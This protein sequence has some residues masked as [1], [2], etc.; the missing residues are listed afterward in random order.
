MIGNLTLPYRPGAYV[1]EIELAT[2]TEQGL[3]NFLPYTLDDYAIRHGVAL[4]DVRPVYLVLPRFDLKDEPAC[5]FFDLFGWPAGQPVPQVKI[6]AYTPAGVPFLIPLGDEIT[7]QTRLTRLREWPLPPPLDPLRGNEAGRDTGRQR[8]QVLALVGNLGRLLWV[9]AGEKA[10]LTALVRQVGRQRFLSSAQGYSLDLIGQEL[11]VPRGYPAAYPLDPATIA[12]YHLDDLEDDPFGATTVGDRVIDTTGRHHGTNEDAERGVEGRFYR[13]FRFR[14]G[15]FPHPNC[16]AEALFQERLRNGDWNAEVGD[17]EVRY[18]P[19]RVFGYRE[20]AIEVPG[21]DGHP[22]GVW[23]NDEAEDPH[24]RGMITSACYGFIPHDLNPTIHHFRERG[25]PVRAAI[26]Y[27]GRWWGRDHGWFI[28]NYRRHGLPEPGEECI[29]PE[30]PLTY[31]RIPNHREFA[32]GRERSFTVEA[33]ILAEP[34]TDVRL[35]VIAIKSHELFYGAPM[36][37]HCAEGWALTLGTFDCIANNVAWSISDLPDDKRYAAPH[38]EPR[39]VT[40]T[41]GLDLAD[42]RWHHVAGVIDRRYQVARLY[43]DGVQR[44]CA[45]ISLVG[46]IINDE[47][48]LLGVNDYHFDAPFDGRIDEVRLSNVARRAFHP[49]LGEGDERYRTRLRLYRPWVIPTEDTLRRGVQEILSES[50]F[51]PEVPALVLPNIDLQEED[52]RRVCAELKLHFRPLS[53]PP[54]GH[55]DG[56]GDRMTSLEEICGAPDE[57]FLEAQLI[58]HDHPDLAYATPNARRM[59]LGAAQAV[60]ALASR[61]KPWF[62]GSGGRLEVLSAYTPGGDPLQT[63]GR[64]IELRLPGLPTGVLAAFA[65]AAGCDWVE[66]TVVGGS[67]VIAAFAARR[68]VLEIA[69]DN[70]ALG[71]DWPERGAE[72]ILELG[73]SIELVVVRP[74]TPPGAT[75]TWRVVS[76]GPGRARLEVNPATPERARLFPLQ[77]GLV[78][79]Q[80]EMTVGR[81]TL[82]GQRAARLRPAVLPPCET[83][84]ADGTLGLNEAEAAGLPTD[85]FHEAFLLPFPGVAGALEWAAAVADQRVQLG[86]ERVLLRL[87]ALLAAE[88]GGAVAAQLVAGYDPQAADLRRLA[89][90]V[91]LT[92]TDPAQL[93]LGRLA[94]LAHAAGFAWVSYPAFGDNIEAATGSEPLLEIVAGPIERLP[95]NGVLSWA[96]ILRADVPEGPLLA[97]E[98]FNAADPANHHNRPEVDY[99]GGTRSHLMQPDLQANLDDLI[100]LLTVENVPGRLQVLGAFDDTAP[101]RRRVGRG[102]T[103]R[104]SDLPLDRLGALAHA[105][106]FDYVRYVTTPALDP[107]THYLYASTWASL[108]FSSLGTLDVAEIQDFGLL[109]LDGLTGLPVGGVR[110]LCLRPNPLAWVPPRVEEPPAGEAPPNLPPYL[111][112]FPPGAHVEFCLVRCDPAWGRLESPPNPNCCWLFARHAV[113]VWARGEFVLNDATDPYRFNL[114]VQ[115][116]AQGDIPALPKALYDDLMNYLSF[117]HPVGVEARTLAV[118]AITPGVIEDPLL[119]GLDTEHTFPLYRQ[120]SLGSPR[121]PLRPGWDWVGCDCPQATPATIAGVRP[122]LPPPPQPRLPPA[123]RGEPGPEGH[124]HENEDA[125]GRR[126]RRRRRP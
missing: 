49:A 21:P 83:I 19:Y 89:R 96:G 105:A 98:S 78:F 118:R 9:L 90:Q 84:S 37:V 69:T 40:V 125:A 88:P 14:S 41:A 23:V 24:V 95:P 115:P 57:N 87:A 103:L 126:G 36:Q 112:P 120:R 47:D 6:P 65:H 73:N 66:H 12:L 27:F 101:N 110:R 43:V 71:K 62:D 100:D 60:D 75:F 53:L 17:R 55:I 85:W 1:Q 116:N 29:F 94:A 25:L 15:P 86:L 10:R 8:W 80:V 106:G 56:G 2:V 59:Q 20:G 79:V 39:M 46:S 74:A 99:V 32:L 38:D 119:A 117:R 48:I 45:D 30:S 51:G 93:S 63:V 4:W 82:R 111:A 104:H 58:Q 31:V 97:T 102:L 91:R 76:C 77:P 44:G 81:A 70:E 34:T 13:A 61:L 7:G 107:A 50:P 123:D 92:P 3:T 109:D 114:V 52:S 35:R 18:G 113:V 26:D 121:P 108:D 72:I 28:E 16:A 54:G 68:E 42:G 122:H 64:Q 11:H 124:G 22:H 33:F 5:L 67:R